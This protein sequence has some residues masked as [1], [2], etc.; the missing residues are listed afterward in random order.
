MLYSMYLSIVY[1][2]LV[3]PLNPTFHYC[4]CVCVEV[5]RS[6]NCGEFHTLAST[7]QSIAVFE[8]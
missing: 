7:N 4:T 8:N 3:Q 6:S 2:M 5:V 1:H